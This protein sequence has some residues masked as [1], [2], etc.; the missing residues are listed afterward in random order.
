MASIVPRE[1]LEEIAVVANDT[2]ATINEWLGNA[3]T[4][5]AATDSLWR[6]GRLLQRHGLS[7][8]Y[9]LGEHWSPL[10][11]RGVI[12]AAHERAGVGMGEDNEMRARL[13]SDMPYDLAS[14]PPLVDVFRARSI[15]LRACDTVLVERSLSGQWDRTTELMRELMGEHHQKAVATSDAT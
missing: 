9:R 12:L 8:S 3:S 15:L 6:L 7:T 2:V 13:A 5:Q 4:R 10:T 1:A 14:G 11:W